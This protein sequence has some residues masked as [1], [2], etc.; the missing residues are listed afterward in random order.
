[1]KRVRM[2][3]VDDSTLFRKVVRDV[4]ASHPAVDVVGVAADGQ[5]A[6]E[7]IEQLEPD[8]VTLDM[9]M[10]N[11]DGLGVLRSIK[12]K[13]LSTGVIMLSS[14]TAQGAQETLQALELGAFDF[15]LKPRTASLEASIAE[16]QGTLLPKIDA[17]TGTST[18]ASTAAPVRACPLTAVNVPPVKRT[19]TPLT[20]ATCFDKRQVIVIGV[21]TG[22]PSALSR[23]IPTLPADLP[24]PVAIVQH[25]PPL[26]TQS[27]ADDLNRASKL[28][29]V[30]ASHGMEFRAG[31]VFI[32]PGGKHMRI[33]GSFVAPTVEITDDA[34]EKNCRPSVDY[35]FRSA[36]KL[37][38]EGVTACVM[39]GMGDDGCDGAR[40]IKQARGRVIAQDASSCTVYGMPRVI[41]ENQLA[42]EICPLDDLAD[43]LLRAV[44]H[45]GVLCR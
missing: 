26:F 35:L 38:G 15:I 29:V 21:S 41:I 33:A 40:I 27:L 24:V 9:Q 1:M 18:F 19:P 32:A 28:R 30:E 22:G 31:T 5:Q 4:V 3:V 6:I 45:R 43:S 11:V 16:L 25:M 20:L 8:L 13:N 17:F 34:P 7:K 39:T 14:F 2:V 36:A 23:L 10:P 37:Y 42:D 12:S 44:G